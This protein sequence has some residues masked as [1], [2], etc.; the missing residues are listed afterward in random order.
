MGKSKRKFYNVRVR[1][2]NGAKINKKYL[3]SSSH[4]AASKY[5]G[6]GFVMWTQKGGRSRLIDDVVIWDNHDISRIMKELRLMAEAKKSRRQE[7]IKD[8]REHAQEVSG[9]IFAG[10][11]ILREIKDKKKE[12]GLDGNKR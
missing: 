1:A 3:A 4:D 12:G 2:A 8:I 11:S 6:P 7:V 9:F 5:K 10:D